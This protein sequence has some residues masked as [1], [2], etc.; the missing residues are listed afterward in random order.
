MTRIVMKNR[1]GPRPTEPEAPA[2]LADARIAQGMNSYLDPADLENGILSL[3]K[4][5]QVRGDRTFRTNGATNIAITKPD[6]NKILLY[7]TWKRFSGTTEYLRFTKNS[8]HKKGG[9]WTALTGTITGS[10]TDRINWT[11]ASD[12][13]ND[14][15]FFANGVDKI[16]KI[17]TGLTA[18]ADL[19]TL[20]PKAR[21][22]FV[23]FNRVVALNI[24]S[25]SPN[26]VLVQWSGDLNFTEWDSTVDVSAGSNPLVEAQSDYNDEI[27]GGFAFAATALIL[28][29]RSLWTVAKRPVASN[30]F[31][32]T[33]AFPSVG[34]DT[35]NSAIQTRN[36]ICWYDNRAN[37][38]YVYEVGNVPIPV[39]DPVRDLLSSSIINRS[40]VQA[41]FDPATNTYILTVPSPISS[42]SRIFK[43]NLTNQAWTYDEVDNIYGTF[44]LDGGT[45]NLYVND[46]VG[47]V[48]S[49]VGV[50]N[51]LTGTS[52][53]ADTY[54]G[55]TDGNIATH[56][57]TSDGGTMRLESKVFRGQADTYISRLMLMVSPRRAGTMS[58]YY[59]RNNGAWTLFKT[60]TLGVVNSRQRIYCV[61]TLLC[62]DF[63]WSVECST[64]DVAILEYKIEAASAPEDK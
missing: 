61:K 41:S 7:T 58:V 1:F 3:A 31:Q 62:N 33:A 6:S 29:E 50:V 54:Y 22:I 24:R 55:K 21:Y 9:S 43:F 34:C 16:Q 4:N 52:N 12:A 20:A 57:S 38:V 35:P 48:D 64:G 47:V 14:Y 5:A 32:F 63:Q 53:I 17:N 46:L 15:F 59:R 26:P 30:P 39:G 25:A 10:D 42:T 45:E 37:Q 56:N 8:V 19:G 18:Y 40:A 51:S 28:R 13:S 2:V 44:F 11:T 49:L 60:V 23:F 27:T 36:G